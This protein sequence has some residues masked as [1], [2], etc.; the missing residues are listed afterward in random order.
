V[1]DLISVIPG[2]SSVDRTGSKPSRAPL[3]AIGRVEGK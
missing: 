3:V 2:A 1:D